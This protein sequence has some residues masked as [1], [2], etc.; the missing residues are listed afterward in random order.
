[1]SRPGEY[2]RLERGSPTHGCDHVKVELEECYVIAGQMRG[3]KRRSRYIIKNMVVVRPKEL[4]DH[5][6]GPAIVEISPFSKEKL[7]KVVTTNN[8]I[9]YAHVDTNH[10]VQHLF[11]FQFNFDLGFT[12]IG[13]R[14]HLP[15]MEQLE[16]FYK[17]AARGRHPWYMTWFKTIPCRD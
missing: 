4:V 11:P 3:N 6:G 10:A 7:H 9:I 17:D 12:L 1:M 16:E 8:P 14:N 5:Y 2:Y 15:P 13:F